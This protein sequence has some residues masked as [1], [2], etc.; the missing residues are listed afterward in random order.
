MNN[1][2][3]LKRKWLWY[4]VIGNYY[5]INR[6]LCICVKVVHYKVFYHGKIKQYKDVYF[7][8]DINNKIYEQ[9]N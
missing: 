6:K 1:I 8:T 3:V 7:T 4:Y 2:I 5:T 9:T